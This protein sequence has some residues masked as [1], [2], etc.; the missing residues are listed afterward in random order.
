MY[1]TLSSPQISNPSPVN[2]EA[3][4]SPC[5]I[6]SSIVNG[7]IFLQPP[8]ANNS[9]NSPLNIVAQFVQEN[10]MDADIWTTRFSYTMVATSGCWFYDIFTGSTD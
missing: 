10:K 3:S 4:S 7:C 8:T 2:H 6:G 9:S 5:P 1:P